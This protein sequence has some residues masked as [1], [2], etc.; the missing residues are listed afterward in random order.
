MANGHVLVGLPARSGARRAQRDWRVGDS[1]QVRVI[2]YD[3]SRGRLIL[4]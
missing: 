3:L 4:E 2:P 1:V